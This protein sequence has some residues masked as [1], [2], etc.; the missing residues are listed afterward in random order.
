MKTET[1]KINYLCKEKTLL[2]TQFKD[3]CRNRGK[4]GHKAARCKSK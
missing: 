3:K 1:A 4:I 2:V